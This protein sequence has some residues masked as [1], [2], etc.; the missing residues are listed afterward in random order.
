MW[1]RFGTPIPG[2]AGSGT[3]AS[4]IGDWLLVNIS[5]TSS[6]DCIDTSVPPAEDAESA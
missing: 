6:L 1:M 2:G 3:E 4:G 5:A